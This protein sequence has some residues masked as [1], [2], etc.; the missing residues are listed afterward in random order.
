MY[1]IEPQDSKINLNKSVT[2]LCSIIDP[3]VIDDFD[4]G[5]VRIDNKIVNTE[6]I[7]ATVLPKKP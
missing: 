3:R 2:E 6:L 4:W 1:W 5:L 7:N